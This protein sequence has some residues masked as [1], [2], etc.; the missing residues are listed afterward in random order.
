MHSSKKFLRAI[1]NSRWVAWFV[2]CHKL[3]SDDPINL[4][5]TRAIP[6]GQ[7]VN[8]LFYY[9]G[10]KERENLTKSSFIDRLDWETDL[11][12]FGVLK[13][14][15]LAA[16]WIVP[17]CLRITFVYSMIFQTSVSREQ[18]SGFVLQDLWMEKSNKN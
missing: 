13:W 12:C 9:W 7:L 3:L 17:C 18:C 4:K 2:S 1:L 16:V 5:Q 10:F 11:V 14:T 8:I 6:N 15:V